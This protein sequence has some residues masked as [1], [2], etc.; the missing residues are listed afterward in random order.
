MRVIVSAEDHAK[1][2][3][4]DAHNHGHLHLVGVEKREAVVG[5]VPNLLQV[6]R[7]KTKVGIKR[8]EVFETVLNGDHG[9]RNA[10]HQL[11]NNQC[12]SS[13]LF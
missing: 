8:T 3:V 9:K 5:Q 7:K 1:A 11:I 2:H 4:D 6:K 10:M 12:F 13:L